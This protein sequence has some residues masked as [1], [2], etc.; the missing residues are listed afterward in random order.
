MRTNIAVWIGLLIIAVLAMPA[1][2]YYPYFPGDV[3]IERWVQSL[4]PRT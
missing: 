4:S 1:A 3:A 2:K